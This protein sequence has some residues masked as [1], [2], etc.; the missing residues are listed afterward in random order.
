V[1]LEF[2]GFL[3]L[4]MMMHD[5]GINSFYAPRYAVPGDG[6]T[7]LTAMH[8]RFGF[9][10]TGTPLASGFKVGGLVEWD[11]F[12]ASANQ[13]RFRTRQVYL[14]LTKGG[15]N[16]LFG[17]AWDVFSPLG[18][19]TLM[20]NGYLW[21][22]GNLGFRRA[23]IRFGQEF[24]HFDFAASV[25]D[26]ASEAGSK[27]QVPLFQS[28]FG[29]RLGPGNKIRIGVSGAYGKEEYKSASYQTDVDV[30][31]LSLDWSVPF[32]KIFEFK[33]ELANGDNLA[34]FLSRASVFNST[35]SLEFQAKNATSSWT[36]LTIAKGRLNGWVG[37]AFEN[38]TITGQ[39]ATGDIA[40]TNAAF[41]G[42]QFKLGKEVSLG[43]EYTYFL[44]ERVGA[45]NPHTHQVLFS[46]VYNF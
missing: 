44:S 43:L 40:D 27:S 41:T 14:N 9:R 22:T 19:T 11:L 18:P 29:V 1:K 17:Q 37:Y 42:I 25:N 38:L 21:Q 35:S 24:K 15:T 45:S 16:L 31:G 28:R 46:A 8:S 39:L 33:G 5:A 2:I 34:T 36:E 4:D 32:G 20:T 7:N 10:W 3:K 6:E 23:Q 13:M 12:D 26:P 30:K